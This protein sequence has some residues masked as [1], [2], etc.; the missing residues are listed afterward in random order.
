MLNPIHRY[1]QESR[2]A[3]IKAC[4][5][6]VVLST[7]WASAWA[8]DLGTKAQTYPLDRDE[9]EQFKDILRRKQQSG[10][11][12]RYMR[13][14]RDKTIEAIKHPAPLGVPSSYAIH[15]ELRELKF[16]LPV[17]YR[18][19][20][21]RVV[22]RRGTVIEPLKIMPLTSGLVFIDGTDPRQVSYAVAR[23]QKEPLK[24]VLTAGSAFDLRVR[25]KNVP[26]RGNPGVPFYFDQHKMIINQMAKLYGIY[27]ASVPATLL[28][29]GDR[30][31][32]EFGLPQER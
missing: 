13:E 29:R 7:T 18:D 19:Q 20:N 14:S 2:L 22:A 11:L 21:G 17:D 23:S 8:E 27:I 28:Q 26:W 4:S 9:R 24:I 5:L 32:V 30:L 25:F 12:D 16:A 15:S 3:W 10:E 6:V 1:G 31:A